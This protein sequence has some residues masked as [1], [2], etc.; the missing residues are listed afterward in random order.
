[1]TK[2]VQQGPKILACPLSWSKHKAPFHLNLLIQTE[3]HS[4][5]AAEKVLWTAWQLDHKGE[6]AE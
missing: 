3:T 6:D 1:M 4:P 2:D 5:S